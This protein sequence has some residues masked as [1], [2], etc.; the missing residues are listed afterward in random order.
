MGGGGGSF[1]QDLNPEEKTKL[2]KL[3]RKD[4]G[5][6]KREKEGKLFREGGTVSASE[7]WV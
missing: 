5:V 7:V 1:R 3:E 2:M 6:R 4:I